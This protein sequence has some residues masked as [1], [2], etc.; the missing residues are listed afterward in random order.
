MIGIHQRLKVIILQDEGTGTTFITL[1]DPQ[2]P[3]LTI[4]NQT[5]MLLALNSLGDEERVYRVARNRMSTLKWGEI[6][7]EGVSQIE[8]RIEG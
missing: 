8:L 6:L 5:A 2:E 3:T 1:R 7:R 4:D